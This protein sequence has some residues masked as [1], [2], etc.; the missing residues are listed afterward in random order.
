MAILTG[1]F[2]A[3]RLYPGF[4]GDPMFLLTLTLW[5]VLSRIVL[6]AW[7]FRF[8][9]KV[10]WTWPIIL[11]VNQVVNAAV[12][13]RLIYFLNRQTWANR[14]NQQAG[15]AKG[16]KGRA[17]NAVAWTQLAITLTLFVW[18]IWQMSGFIEAA[19]KV[20][21]GKLPEGVAQL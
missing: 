15:E 20:Q 7:L 1:V 10:D 9:E 17:L 19:L 11:Y 6:S 18:V 2:W 14:G 8:A 5:V 13:V 3:A 4:A 21:T 12:K 16:W